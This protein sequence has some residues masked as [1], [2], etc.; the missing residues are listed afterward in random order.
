MDGRLGARGRGTT[1]GRR[2][3]VMTRNLS[4]PPTIALVGRP[5]AGKGTQAQLLAA[6]GCWT[7]LSTGDLL[8]EE[9]MSSSA[10]GL[11][12]GRYVDQG[13]LVPNRLVLRTLFAQ[14]EPLRARGRPVVLD[15]FPRTVP[16]SLALDQLLGPQRLDLVVELDIP[17][18][19][20]FDRLACRARN[21]DHRTAIERRLDAF[22]RV[23]APM[24][25]WY[26]RSGRARR[27]DGSHSVEDLHVELLALAAPLLV[28]DEDD[29][30]HAA[31]AVFA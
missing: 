6:S 16:Q 15:G 26:R 30:S 3:I 10:T 29:D 31:G 23:T 14:L 22:D 9:M 19:L 11:A 21:D 2:A 24:L 8:R 12:V 1:R 18:D 7:S 4:H 17:R 27:V 5:G 13:L 20:A 25:D 28:D